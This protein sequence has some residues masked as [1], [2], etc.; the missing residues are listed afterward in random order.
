MVLEKKLREQ[1]EYKSFLVGH[2]VSC[3]SI[4]VVPFL[5]QT[6]TVPL[7][8]IPWLSWM[9]ARLCANPPSG[10]LG[11]NCDTQVALQEKFNPLRTVNICIKISSQNKL[12]WLYDS[13]VAL[14]NCRGGANHTKCQFLHNV[15][16]R[17]WR[18]ILEKRSLIIVSHPYR[19]PNTNAWGWW[20]RTE[21]QPNTSIHQHEW[22]DS[23]FNHPFPESL[24]AA[25]N[26]KALDLISV[27]IF[28]PGTKWWANQSAGQ[29]R[30]PAATT[31]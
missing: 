21:K 20:P 8:F 18:A 16:L 13:G 7:L 2:T 12:M 3:N 14:R 9:S 23:T 25:L 22:W 24:A 29:H 5:P 10:Y 26:L 31:A 17:L 27:K 28:Q 1:I 15:A 30:S 4:A 19:L 6:T 11:G